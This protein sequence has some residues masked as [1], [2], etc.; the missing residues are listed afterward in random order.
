MINVFLIKSLIL[1][2][3]SI[4]IQVIV[5]N[6]MIFFEKYSPLVYITWIYAYSTNINKYQFLILTFLLGLFM[7]TF[8]LTGG[9]HASSC[10]LIGFLRFPIINKIITNYKYKISKNF[11]NNLSW[12]QKILL[13]TIMVFIHHS[14]IFIIEF[15]S[16]ISITLILNHIFYNSLITII[17]SI[18]LII[19]L[20]P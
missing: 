17:F 19:I 18:L 5:F 4:F 8:F 10:L 7:D 15:L 6:Q 20:N 1:L 14:W 9:V 12:L 16:L 11:I 2:F 13:I 3:I